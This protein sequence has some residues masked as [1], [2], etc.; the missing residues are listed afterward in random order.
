MKPLFELFKNKIKGKKVAVVGVG[1]S[2]TP[3]IKFL[4]KL[5]ARVT[6]FDKRSEAELQENIKDF[7]EYIELSTGE[8]YLSRLTG[9]DIIFRTPGM[10][11]D[12]PE[13]LKAAEEGA[14]ITSE[15]MEFLRYCKGKT[16]G[17]TGSDGKSTT[18]TMTYE[19][20]KKAG[21]SAY[22]G[23][24]I[25]FPL[26]DKIE[27]ITE[28]D[29]VVLELSSFQLMDMDVSTDIAVV[30]N[31][32]PNHLDVHKDMDE[33]IEAK[34][35]IFKFQ[36]EKGILIINEDNEI[37]RSFAPEAKGEVKFF[38][39]KVKADAYYEDGGIYLKD[40]PVVK[41]TDMKVRGVHNAENLCAAMLATQGNVEIPVIK[42]FAENFPGVH[43]RCEFVREYK[44][45]RY[46][47]DSIAS[48]PTRTM[49]TV[50][51]FPDY[52]G[53]INI[54]LG[55]YDKN[56]PFENLVEE[57]SPYFR[58]VILVGASKPKILDAFLKEDEKARPNIIQADTFEDA[59]EKARD[60]AKE[61]DLVL[62]SPANA[63]FDMFKNF[64]F[65]G[66]KF[67]ELVDSFS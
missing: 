27:E 29:I 34:K 15:M 26:F 60:A 31:L 47:N 32:S 12:T 20:L 49:A 11:P 6:A 39:S 9:F 16:I 41:L 28:E 40:E 52:K 38:S 45:V 50:R 3:L 17:I 44:G 25:G 2:N 19:L 58:N 42:D 46:Y 13:L 5:G 55:G 54:I 30:T 61:G 56:L 67:K 51:S 36:D 35:N 18:T 24:N 10:R 53:R 23:G 8:D 64:E 22:L 1:V 66:K 14:E 21:H 65:R 37:T 48:S 63:S 62:M 33:Y 43:H 7:A 57:G 59:V 4:L